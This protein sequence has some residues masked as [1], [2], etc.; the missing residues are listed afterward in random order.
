MVRMGNRILDA[1]V[2]CPCCGWCGHEFLMLDCD[3]FTVPSAECPQCGNHERHRLLDLYLHR[4]DGSFYRTGGRVLHLAPEPHV[5]SLISENKNLTCFSLDFD[6]DTL[7]LVKGLRVQTDI[8]A[9]G[10][11]TDAFDFLFCLHVLEHVTDDAKGIRELYRILKPGGVAYIM[12]PLMLGWPKTIEFE[13]PDP[14]M[15]GHV[16][17]YA[18]PDF[19]DRL[20]PFAFTE[21]TADSFLTDEEIRRFRIPTDSQILYRCL[22]PEEYPSG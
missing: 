2:T 1:R 14:F 12:V 17:G 3:T 6:F 8:Q 13:Q 22:K 20:T 16:R 18:P 21:I 15:F 9:L 19:K 10:I 5:R 4:S 11:A 7:L